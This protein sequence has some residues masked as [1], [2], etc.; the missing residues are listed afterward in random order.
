[1]SRSLF[2]EV[3]ADTPTDAAAPAA[4][5]DRRA[6]DRR[7]VR[8]WLLILAGMVV[9][10]ILIGGLTR[11][12]ESGLSITEWNLVTGVLPPLSEVG[13]LSEFEKY[14][15]TTEYQDVNAGM[16]L[17]DFKTI[18]YWEWGHRIWGR[19]IGLATLLP[20]AFFYFRGRIPAGLTPRLS[21]I[22]GLVLLQGVVGWWMVTSGLVGRTDVS[23]YRLAAH[24]GLAFVLLGLLFWTA[25][26][27]K[28]D[29]TAAYAARR[30]REGPSYTIATVVF[31]L[32][33]L[34]I[35]M[36]AIVAGVDG[37]RVYAEWPTMDGGFY[38]ANEP[39]Q[40]FENQAAAQFTHRLLG[41]VLFAA[42]L[43]AWFRLRRSAFAKTR[44]WA[45]L[46]LG[47]VLVQTIIGILTVLNHAALGWASLHQ[48][49]GVA[50]FAIAV[51]ALRQTGWPAA[52]KLG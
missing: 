49:G 41:Y 52:E 14:K 30:R 16:A 4:A 8:L 48:L 28:G 2:E 39:F 42:T 31:G 21:L 34:Q 37:G 3:G 6:S 7:A 46:L 15:T 9:A 18:Y 1:M 17:G 11:L 44:L 50:V 29:E 23:Q 5:A 27:L 20:L 35:L 40:P 33:C 25:L 24:L 38:P 36:G 10:Q 43:Y 32:V 47:G 26:G 45:N 12:T 51:H 13:W 22:A 19:L